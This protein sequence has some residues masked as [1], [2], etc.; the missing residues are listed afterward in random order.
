M[1]DDR[2]SSFGQALESSGF[3][4]TGSMSDAPEVTTPVA[5]SADAS[6]ASPSDSPSS[7]AAP[8]AASP[9]E[10]PQAA[11]P[12]P[13]PLPY[14]RHKA[15]LDKAYAER[16]AL[17]AQVERAAWAQQVPAEMGPRLLAMAQRVQGDPVGFLRELAAEIQSDPRHA[18]A[19]RSYAA[20]TLAQRPAA[21]A[22]TD[23]EP[24]P[25]IVVDGH[26]WYSAE[27][28]AK[29]EAWNARKL[30]DQL[31]AVVQERV[32]PLAELAQRVASAEAQQRQAKEA[33]AFAT[34]H[35]DRVS[36][37]PGFKE[38]Q[39]EI[40]AAFDAAVA[41]VPPAD[42]DR[43]SPTILRDVYADVVLPKLTETSNQTLLKTLTA[44]ASAAS[45]GTRPTVAATATRPRS[46]HEAFTQAG[47][48]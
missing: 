18:A 33:E 47:I 46:M 9:T 40:S 29:R 13:G 12:P 44:K 15:I 8:A 30:A 42:R 20:S 28:Q 6:S 7:E 41:K 43:L 24:G 16:D 11:E 3:D 32:G 22:V 27:Q 31:G 35:F 10:T 19:L 34:E 48:T 36:R 45:L 37:L 21:A 1:S 4:A 25:D 17:K 5:D 38:H 39:A 23:E 14:E 26:R 2:P